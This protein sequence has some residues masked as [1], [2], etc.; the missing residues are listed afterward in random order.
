MTTTLLVIALVLLVIGSGFFSSSEVA[1]FYLN[2]LEIRRMRDSHPAI[3]R[4]A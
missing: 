4:R 3:V 2:P 1:Y